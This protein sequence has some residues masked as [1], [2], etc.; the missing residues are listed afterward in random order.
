MASEDVSNI[1]IR[2]VLIV[3][4]AVIVIFLVTYY[5]NPTKKTTDVSE[6]K[7]VEKFNSP[8]TPMST[9]EES[10]AVRFNTR[11]PSSAPSAEDTHFAYASQALR[12]QSIGGRNNEPVPYSP[13][14]IEDYIA[15]DFK[16]SGP[17][18]PV[19]C[20]P[21]DRT[22]PED[23]L[24]KDA[25]NSKWAQM[26]PAG[27][28]DVK[29]QNFLSAGFHIGKDSIGVARKNPNLTFR[30]EPANPRT[31]VSP[32]NIS[33]IEPDTMRRGFEIV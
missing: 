25:A 27:Q 12:P 16:T 32:W 3:L 29:D 14:D 24:P 22:T 10:R 13:N 15:V 1:A 11:I 26:A 19:N 7:G 28:G 31:D 33:T 6:K 17:N 30:A 4:A 21:Q 18:Q 20:F 2:V 9:Q 23:L 5:S 8:V